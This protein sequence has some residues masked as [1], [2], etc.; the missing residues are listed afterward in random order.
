MDGWIP[1]AS[2]ARKITREADSPQNTEHSQT[3]SLKKIQNFAELSGVK[4]PIF[5]EIAS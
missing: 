5:V 2:V 4:E 1:G 3:M